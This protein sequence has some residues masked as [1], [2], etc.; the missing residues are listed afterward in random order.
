MT[1]LKNP[2][3]RD[4]L[5]TVSQSART[6]ARH[7]TAAAR[8]SAAAVGNVVKPVRDDI[9]GLLRDVEHA[10]GTLKHETSAEAR[11]L[12]ASLQAR[13]H[14]LREFATDKA[15]A[16]RARAAYAVDET[17]RYVRASPLKAIGIAA[18]VGAIIGLL[19]ASPRHHK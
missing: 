9:Q 10:A 4:E 17:E 19:L 6:T 15:A 2:R 5:D 8:E 14:E 1:L 12:R 3:L 16:A 11:A 18:A 13:A 7:A